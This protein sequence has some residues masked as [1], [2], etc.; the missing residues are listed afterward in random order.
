MLR[1]WV[2]ARLPVH[3]TIFLTHG[4]NAARATFRDLLIANGVGEKQISM[5]MLD[6]T[7]TLRSGKEKHQAIPRRLP[8]K[9]MSEE[10]W[11]NKYAK[12]IT[13]LSEKLAGVQSNR[14]R[15]K[16]LEKLLQTIDRA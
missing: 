12:T 3:K 10:D 14:E 8:G 6:D 1:D 5:P 11:H 7:V 4:E 2:E 13:A 9:A 16:L 15:E